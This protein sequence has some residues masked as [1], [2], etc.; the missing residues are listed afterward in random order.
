M[1]ISKDLPPQKARNAVLKELKKGTSDSKHDFRYLSMATVDPEN[2]EPSVRMLVLRGVRD[3][4]S[5]ILY[6]DAR[7]AKIDE[8]LKNDKASLLFWHSYHKVQVSVKATVKVHHNNETAL[9]YWKKDVHGQAQKAY[10]PEVS[11]GTPID[12][13]EDAYNWPDEYTPANFC[14]LE[15]IA[16]DLQ[17]LQIS[18]K[19]HIRHHFK[20]ADADSD[21]S[22]GWIAP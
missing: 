16:N 6:S 14:V 13:P 4:W 9:D 3:D 21:W 12:K 7:T 10:T 5:F 15:C 19:E 8:L 11:P 20:R 1:L 17:L 2:L 18:G 22:G